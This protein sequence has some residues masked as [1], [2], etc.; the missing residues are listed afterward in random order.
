MSV[1]KGLIPLIDRVHV[2]SPDY[3][4]TLKIRLASGRFFD[5]RDGIQTP[6][7]VIINQTMARAIWGNENALGR[8]IRMSGEDEW[9][10]IVGVNADVKNNGVDKPT[11]TELYLPFSQG[12]MLKSVHIAVR[13]Q[14]APSAI[15]SA[16]RRVMHDIDPTLPLTKI[17]TLDEVVS[18]TQSR[19]LFL[20]LLLTSF[21]S[22]ALVLAA[23]GFTASFRIRSHKERESLV[24]GW[25]SE[26]RQAR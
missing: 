7:V 24:F 2:I 8:R 14:S 10:T 23:M 15:L 1:E 6:K 5:A 20:T 25:R 17:H 4:D 9:R 18:E 11:G 3:F 12:Y 26:H 22:V 19:P 16:I 21:A 13:S